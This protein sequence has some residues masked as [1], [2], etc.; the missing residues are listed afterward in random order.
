MRS[1]DLTGQRFGM[2]VVSEFVER[3]K[4]G[5][6]RWLCL[7]DCGNEA[8][9]TLGNLRSGHS[10]SCGCLRSTTT[11]REKTTHG[12]YGTPTY[13]SWSSM[14]TRCNNPANHKYPDYGGRGI[15]VCE[16]WHAFESFLADM[17]ERP[18]G[19]TIGR[20]DNDGHYDPSNCQWESGKKQGRNKRNTRLFEHNGITATI[21]EHCER[22]GINASSVRSRIY[23]YG[24]GVDKALT[25]PIRS[26]QQ[27]QTA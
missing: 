23:T 13:K 20:I 12:M 14:I 1:I 11:T 15:K 2:L 27:E 18:T 17:G 3:N 10:K 19:K 25:T 24:W 21:S 4:R 22:L 8:V 5:M 26:Q 6:A 7:C 16:R 9:K